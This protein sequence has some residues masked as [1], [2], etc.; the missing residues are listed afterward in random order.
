MTLAEKAY[1]SLRHDILRGALAAGKPLRLADLKARYGMG[2]SPLRE[3][4]NRLQ[5]ERLVLAE[6]L[7]GFR[8][9]SLSLA[10]MQD[11]IATR[12][13][14]E[15]QALRLAIA[16]GTDAWQA[17]IVAALYSLQQ[18]AARHGPDADIWQLEARHH[19]FHRALLEPCGSPWLMEFFERL[20]AATE[21]Y[22][23]PV[24]LQSIQATGRDI[25][26]E[27]AALA[28]A[29]LARDA[30]LA[31]AFLTRHYQG[32]AAAIAA[33]M[34]GAMSGAMSGAMTGAGIVP[35]PEAAF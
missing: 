26:A 28:E 12:I 1:A 2:F 3:A 19:A 32:T 10:E 30:D 11:S 13:V 9:A 34:T 31:V 25:Q 29:T 17:G 21:R 14:I 24:L 4:L 5:A 22:R 33:A 6:A 7:R 20:Y 35:A 27:H 8:V 16:N 23:I 15:T 18:Q